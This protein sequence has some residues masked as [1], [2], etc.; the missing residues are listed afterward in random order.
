[1]LLAL[2]FTTPTFTATQSYLFAPKGIAEIHITLLNGKT[3]D[4]IKREEIDFDTEKLE[5]TMQIVKSDR[6]TYDESELYNG[7]IEIKGRG[8]T[9]WGRPKKPYSIDL[10]DDKGEDNPSALLGMPA[11]E[12]W[13]LIAF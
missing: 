8:N 6:S 4:D 2:C 5:A 3:I 10:I 11:D 12:E 7:K 13:A 1:M 9:T